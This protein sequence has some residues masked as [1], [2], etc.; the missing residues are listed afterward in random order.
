M[1]D[2]MSS[3]K[4]VKGM[5]AAK[6]LEKIVM[7]HHFKGGEHEVHEFMPHEGKM[8]MEHV[9]KHMGVGPGT[10]DSMKAE[11]EDGEDTY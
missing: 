1:R 7:T 10:A 2:V 9:A 3:G 11:E 8:A 5:K 4:Q 6:S